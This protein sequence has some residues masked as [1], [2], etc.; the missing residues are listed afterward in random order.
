MPETMTDE[1]VVTLSASRAD[2]ADSR[3]YHLRAFSRESSVVCLGM[4]VLGLAGL[5]TLLLTG[6]H[7]YLGGSQRKLGA[8]QGKGM[9][10]VRDGTDLTGLIVGITAML[11]VG[12]LIVSGGAIPHIRRMPPLAAAG[13]VLAAIISV[14]GLLV[15]ALGS[16]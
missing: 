13:V 9:A 6:F 14:S 11:L 12:A 10:L 1:E 2:Q 15:M 16:S 5:T 7:V 8:L 4:A 3:E